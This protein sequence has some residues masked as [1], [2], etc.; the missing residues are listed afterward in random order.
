MWSKKK[1]NI[2]KQI[3]KIKIK[4]IFL[5]AAFFS[6]IKTNKKIFKKISKKY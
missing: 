3:Q 5:K 1:V 4:K 6:T 2:K